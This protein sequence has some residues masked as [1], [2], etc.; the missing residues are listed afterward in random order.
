MAAPASAADVATMK[1]LVEG[2]VGPSLT[3]MNEEIRSLRKK[4]EALTLEAKAADK[5][6]RTGEQPPNAPLFPPVA[7]PTTIAP[8]PGDKNL[9]DSEKADLKFKPNGEKLTSTDRV[10]VSAKH[11]VLLLSDVKQYVGTKNQGVPYDLD[12]EIDYNAREAFRNY[13]EVERSRCRL[14]ALSGSSSS[15]ST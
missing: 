7:S 14:T 9:S 6:W 5:R 3:I 10:M 2:W 13:C 8:N 11:I 15:A 4:V 1:A 12:K